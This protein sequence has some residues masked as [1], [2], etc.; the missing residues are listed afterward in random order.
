MPEVTFTIAEPCHENWQ[1]MTAN[2]QGRFCSSCKK[3]VVDFSIMSDAQVYS[4]LLKGD[5]NM[6]GRFS[7]QQMEKGIKYGVAKKS[8]WHR[9]FI[10]FLFPAFLYSK[11]A[12]A[13]MGLIAVSPD[14]KI[15]SK[16]SKKTPVLPPKGFQF[17]GKILDA[18]T[19]ELIG[20]GIIK[21]KRTGKEILVDENGTF[22]LNSTTNNSTVT[23][24]VEA[25]GYEAKEMEIAIPAYDFI[26]KEEAIYLRRK[27]IPLE[28]VTV[29][30]NTE[31]HLYVIAGGITSRVIINRVTDW[32]VKIKTAITDSLKIYPNPVSRGNEMNVALKLKKPGNYTMQIIDLSGKIIY[33][34]QVNAIDKRPTSKVQ[35][36][37]AWSSGAYMMRILGTDGALQ[38]VARFVVK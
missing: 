23:I 37:N 35:C 25:S 20:S 8:Y 26:L 30:S 28:N 36:G 16:N 34:Q 3:D 14:A 7:N 38:S 5:A 21:I 10:G 1:N 15:Q 32:P 12:S 19:N 27:I 18:T 4:A 17:S 33:Q 6:C 11:Q 13:Q 24:I 29:R 22:L 9:Y 2:D 31:N